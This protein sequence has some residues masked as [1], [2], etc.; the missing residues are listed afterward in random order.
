M[1]ANLTD[2]D[3]ELL[4]LL[5]AGLE[6]IGKPFALIAQQLASNEATV[7]GATIRLCEA[8]YIKRISATIDHSRLGKTSALVT[9]HVAQELVE[10][11]GSAVS[12]LEGVSH[13][14]IRDHYFNLWFTLQGASLDEMNH[15]ID[16]IAKRYGI[17]FH[18]LPAITTFKLDVRFDAKSSGRRLLASRAN[19]VLIETGEP[20]ELSP[21][22]VAT[23]RKLQQPLAI[24]SEPFDDIWQIAG[25]ITSGVIKRIG[26]VVDYRKLGF[27][28]NAMFVCEV[29]E[30]DIHRIGQALAK[31]ENVSHCYQRPAF[32]NWP[33]NL[34]AMLHGPDMQS[35]GETVSTFTKEH[36]IVSFALLQTIKEL[37]KTP[38]R[39]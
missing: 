4:N 14:Y 37:K 8:G 12:G 19:P 2:F 5:Q 7:L 29:K 18:I 13:N 20:V 22:Q 11:V 33:Y 35:L 30:S 23:I 27:A 38:V 34:F 9:A 39:V 28:A 3:K 26:A 24:V 16:P 25:L 10:D 31:L 36:A 6:P 1:T 15:T 17:E 21:Q 32:E